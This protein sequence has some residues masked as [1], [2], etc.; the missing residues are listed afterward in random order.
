LL[1]RDQR[2]AHARAAYQKLVAVCEKAGRSEPR[3]GA[4]GAQIKSLT[5]ETALQ[6]AETAAD[7]KSTLSRSHFDRDLEIKPTTLMGQHMDMPML[8]EKGVEFGD[9]VAEF[10]R[11]PLGNMDRYRCLFPANN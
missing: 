8:L 1:L 3:L 5:E 9:S 10:R 11:L 2:F 7:G 6:Y 4:L